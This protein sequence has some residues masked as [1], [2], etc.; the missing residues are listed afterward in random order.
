M[1]RRRIIQKKKELRFNKLLNQNN[2]Q[3]QA[4]QETPT[5]HS[6]E[7]VKE[8]PKEIPTVKEISTI[9]TLTD[10]QKQRED[11]TN[12]INNMFNDSNKQQNELLFN[13]F[14][15]SSHIDTCNIDKM[16]NDSM[17]DI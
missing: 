6:Q 11:E 16:I 13:E 2:A 8:T 7:E 1:N 17:T 15:N 5:A 12:E 3:R 4:V 9:Q 14:M 10:I